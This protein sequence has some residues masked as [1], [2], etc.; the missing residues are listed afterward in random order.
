MSSQANP[1][2]VRSALAGSLS[3]DALNDS[4][5]AAVRA[6]WDKRIETA[7]RSLNYAAAFEQAHEAYSEADTLGNVT[8]VHPKDD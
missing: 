5:Q 8:T 1:R 3:Y 6:A 7:H 4:E 2:R